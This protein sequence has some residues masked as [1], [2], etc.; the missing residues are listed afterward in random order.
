MFWK[1]NIWGF[2]WLLVILIACATPGEQLPPSPFLDFDKL[3]HLGIFAILQLLLLRG[4]LLQQNFPLLKKNYLL[5]A[6]FLSV[7]YGVL[8][9]VLQGFVF[10]NRSF[11]W[12]DIIANVAGV[13]LATVMWTAFLG[14]RIKV[15][16]K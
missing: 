5:F 9:E 14:K 11:D 13:V 3:I 2:I 6:T 15:K 10:R 12:F 8:M 16:I 4:L 1:Y 7:D